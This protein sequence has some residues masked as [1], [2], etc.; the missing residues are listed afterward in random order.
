VA[1][2]AGGAN[3]IYSWLKTGY[4]YINDVNLY[5]GGPAAKIFCDIKPRLRS[6]S[7]RH[8]LSNTSLLVSGT[9]WASSFEHDAR[10][11]AQKKKIKSIAVV[12]H[13]TNY[14]ERFSR[15]GKE[16]LPDEIWVTDKYAMEIAKKIL[17]EVHISLHRNDYLALQSQE[18]RKFSNSKREE[19]RGKYF[20]NVLFVMEPTNQSWGG[21]KLLGEIQAFEFFIDNM[22][23]LEI[24]KDVKIIIK[25]HP[26]DEMGKYD[27]CVSKHNNL[28]LKIESSLSLAE[29]IAWS[30]IVVGCQTYAMVV[31][32]EAG[33]R[34]VSSIPPYAPKCILPYEQIM[35]LC[36]LS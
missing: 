22:K 36:N 13:W 35:H 2:D 7:L 6:N 21:S 27:Y 16:V 8:A 34:V 14:R 15:D 5:V 26:A 28:S 4:L 17:P 18:I 30:D 20:C 31:A 1:H 23:L 10:V 9:G 19:S 12:D 33:K 3:H 11:L 29:L 24:G 25:P 32:L